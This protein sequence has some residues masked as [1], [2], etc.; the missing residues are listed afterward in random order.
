MSKLSV[1]KQIME[2]DSVSLTM[3]YE[4]NREANLE[5]APR[6][7]RRP[8]RPTLAKNRTGSKTKTGNTAVPTPQE[9][10]QVAEKGTPAQKSSMI[11]DLMRFRM[12]GMI[13]DGEAGLGGL[14]SFFQFAFLNKV[15]SS[16]KT[17][18]VLGFAATKGGMAALY[19]LAA[20]VGGG[21]GAYFGKKLNQIGSKDLDGEAKE[22]I[23]AALNNPKAAIN[24]L[25]VY[26]EG[27]GKLCR[28]NGGN[29]RCAKAVPFKR[30]DGKTV[31][32]VKKYGPNKNFVGGYVYE[33]GEGPGIGDGRLMSTDSEL[34]REEYQKK[35]AA[36]LGH[37]ATAIISSPL[38]VIQ[39]LARPLTSD[40]KKGY[41]QTPG[42]FHVNDVAMMLALA[43][44]LIKHDIESG[45][46]T[47]D[48][49][50]KEYVVNDSWVQ[51]AAACH[52]IGNFIEGYRIWQSSICC[53]Q[54]TIY[55][56]LQ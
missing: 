18:K 35:M 43:N 40:A 24:E 34:E 53:E 32:R 39:K 1:L 52:H 33:G 49:S 7:P 29:T 51:R 19:L 13:S 27:A 11:T 14:L 15:L 37:T 55:K 38:A 56:T 21:V 6:F 50:K 12:M 23:S 48:A 41:I 8:A 46:I 47:Y 16:P 5:E 25:L 44:S 36:S 30:K 22:R 9:V 31:R 2:D 20:G 4:S 28:R 54:R 10:K 45:N 3:L 26:C 42:Q 17:A